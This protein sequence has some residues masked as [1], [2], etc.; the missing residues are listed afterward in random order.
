MSDWV[1][2]DTV[3]TY[4]ATGRPTQIDRPNGIATSETWDADNRL[5]RIAEGT[6]SEINLTLDA[7]GQI[8]AATRNVP[9]PLATTIT[10]TKLATRCS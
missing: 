1:G 8:V 4:D 5:V 6:V 7:R 2:G 9:A 10:S 3:F